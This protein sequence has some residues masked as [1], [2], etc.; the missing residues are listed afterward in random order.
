M[1]GGL[2]RKFQRVQGPLCKLK[3]SHCYKGQMEKCS[4]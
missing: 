4:T 1:S 2:V 3:F